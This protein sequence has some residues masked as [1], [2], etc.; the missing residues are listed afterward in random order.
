M[1]TSVDPN[2]ADDD[3]D[4]HVRELII[5]D[6]KKRAE[7]YGQTG[8]RA[9]LSSN[10]YVTLFFSWVLSYRDAN[11]FPSHVTAQT[12]MH[13]KRI[14]ASFHL[15][16]E[17]QMITIRLFSELKHK[18]LRR[19]NENAMNWKERRGGLEQRRLLRLNECVWDGLAVV[20]AAAV[21][22]NILIVM[23]T[24]KKAGIGGTEGLGTGTGTPIERGNTE[25]GKN[26]MVEMM[27]TTATT[28]KTETETRILDVGNNVVV[29]LGHRT[30]KAKIG[31]II[32]AAV[33]TDVLQ[34]GIDPPHLL[35]SVQLTPEV[36]HAHFP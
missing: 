1:G 13:P 8:I 3:L 21:D 25:I 24:T 20:L 26:G 11:A 22:G 18:L 10:L 14:N 17:A 31:N 12:A 7:K 32:E 5:K 6:A 34:V 16:Y 33:V 19:L 4:R 36:A 23:T 27:K 29:V 15:S 35:L 30:A 9:Y 28:R 2:V